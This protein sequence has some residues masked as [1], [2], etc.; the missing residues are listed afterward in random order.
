MPSNRILAICLDCGDTLIDESTE[1][2]TKDEISLGADLIPGAD[3]LLHILKQRG[4]PLA[5]VADGPVKTFQNNLGPYGLLE[6]FEAVT[7]SETVGVSKPHPDMF[8][9]AMQ[10]LG[11]ETRDF[12]QVV[13]VGNH[14][15]RDIKGV[16]KLGMISVWLD[17]APRRRKIPRDPSEV[18]QYTITEPLALLQVL[19]KLEQV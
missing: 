1:I 7:I 2:K 3:K 5:L 17:W 12:S 19:D 16:N 18:P 14:L 9:D 13:M 6:L 4:Y 8:F 11:I 15:G 10:Q